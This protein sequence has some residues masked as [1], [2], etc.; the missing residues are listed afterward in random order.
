MEHINED[1]EQ[2]KIWPNNHY[3]T[4]VDCNKIY[5]VFFWFYFSL[6]NQF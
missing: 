4:D 3:I 5:F 2:K 1:E 6:Y